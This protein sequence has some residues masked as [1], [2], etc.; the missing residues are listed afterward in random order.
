MKVQLTTVG[1]PIIRNLGTITSR[2]ITLAPPKGKLL[3]YKHIREYCKKLE[4][5]H[6]PKGSTLVVRAKNIIRDTTLYSSYTTP[7]KTDDQYDK[8]LNGEV[9]ESEKYKVF[10][11]FT[12]SIKTTN[13]K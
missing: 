11:N 8:Y 1:E 7:W 9:E 4:K 10:Y 12:V 5:D 6:L 3:T 2:Q 13:L